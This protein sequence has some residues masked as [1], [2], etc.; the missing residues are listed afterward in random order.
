MANWNYRCY[1][2]GDRTN[3]WQR[4]YDEHPQAQGAHDAAFELLE[5]MQVWQPP[6]FKY[7][8]GKYKGLGEVRFF[9]RDK[10]QWRVF[11]QLDQRSQRYL[12]LS[13]GYHKGKKYTPT[14]VME[15]AKQRL[16]EVTNDTQKAV[17]CERPGK[18]T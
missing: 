13:I 11:G 3:L 1:D 14:N 12:V 5:Q 7:L 16:S 18:Q 15:K 4:W 6:N 2:D 10:L 17:N 8:R 9:G